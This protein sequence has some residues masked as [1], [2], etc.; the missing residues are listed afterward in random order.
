MVVAAAVLVPPTIWLR[1][2]RCPLEPTDA[3]ELTLDGCRR[4]E[5][6]TG[7]AGGGICVFCSELGAAAFGVGISLLCGDAGGSSFDATRDPG[8][9]DFVEI[10]IPP[11][12][13]EL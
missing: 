11:G 10:P 8:M 6:L 2:R 12:R 3:I 7:R 9:A 1:A 4:D 5:D 13:S